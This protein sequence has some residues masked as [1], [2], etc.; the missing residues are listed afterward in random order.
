MTEALSNTIRHSYGEDANQ[1]IDLS[2]AIDAERVEFTILD[3]GRPF[4]PGEYTPP[5][6]DDPG[7]GGYGVH[8]VEEL[9]DELS[10]HTRAD[11]ATLVTLV[12]YRREASDQ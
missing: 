5:D 9:T 2:L 7:E 8:I 3:R 10:R 6:F 1:L 4:E 12:K 11:G